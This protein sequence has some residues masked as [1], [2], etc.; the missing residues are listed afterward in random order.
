M[1]NL[2]TG[3]WRGIAEQVIAEPDPTKLMAL[4]EQLCKEMNR[5]DSDRSPI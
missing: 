2:Q 4:V 1:I 3:A 5:E